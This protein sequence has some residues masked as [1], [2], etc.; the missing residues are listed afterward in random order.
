MRLSTWRSAAS[1]DEGFSL[2]EMMVSLMILAMVTSG[3]AY[4]LN[5]AM[6]VTREDRARVQATNLAARE[7][8]TLRN[9][10]G[11]SKTA[12][13]SIGAL[14]G[15]INPHQLPGATQGDPL[16][17][18]GREFTVVRTVEWLPAG[19]GTSPCD[20][21]TA[22]T[23]PSLGVNVQVS[24]VEGGEQRDVESN[25]VLTPP[26]GTLASIEGFIAAKVT[27]ADGTGVAS[28]PVDIAGPGGSQTRVTA[29]DGCAVFALTTVGNYTVTLD[30]EGYVSFDGQET[31]SKQA[32]VS[33]GSIQVVP[34]SYDAAATLELEYVMAAEAGTEFLM[35]TPVPAVTLF[36]ASL[37]T[38]GK[39]EIS[40]G[41]TTVSG[42][43]PYPDGYSVWAGTCLVNDP[44]TT[45]GS[46]ADPET[47]DPGQ[48]VTAEVLLQPVQATYVDEEGLPIVGMEIVAT[49]TDST[50]CQ[51][52]EFL[53]G[54]TD[55]AGV[56][57]SGLPYGSWTLTGEVGEDDITFAANMP[58]DGSVTYPLVLPLGDIE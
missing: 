41:T 24:W 4:G 35:P 15:V 20:G 13:T 45:G 54:T 32:A 43:W 25:T 26:K 51:E 10:F 40:S 56:V 3:F 44:A 37:P 38:M 36:N 11:A 29:A 55:D 6:A 9:E 23:Y 57:R 7:L 19:T 34:F 21:G 1:D 47:P 42:L 50:G 53:L 14:S 22:V 31:T 33:E 17:L 46:R 39:L 48:T 8:E 49:T 18:D 12:P 16:V 28:L 52:T 30:E 2:V 5:L 27:G 58:A